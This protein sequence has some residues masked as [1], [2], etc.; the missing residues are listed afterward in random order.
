[1][2][3]VKRLNQDLPRSS[4]AKF[5][6]LARLST[7][8]FDNCEPKTRGAGFRRLPADVVPLCEGTKPQNEAPIVAL[9]GHRSYDVRPHLWVALDGNFGSGG[10]T[11][12]SGIRNLATKPAVESI[13]RDYSH[14]L[15]S[16]AVD[17]P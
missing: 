1:M 15:L 6:P 12:L 9:E 5:E 7:V 16:Q 10:I 17:L 8:N 3:R 4:I 13:I 11:A 14:Y 2:V